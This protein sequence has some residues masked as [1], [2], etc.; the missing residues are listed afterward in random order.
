ME[1]RAARIAITAILQL[2]F[3]P[4]LDDHEIAIRLSRDIVHLPGFARLELDLRFLRCR[5]GRSLDVCRWMCRLGAGWMSGSGLWR[6]R[7]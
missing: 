5:A 2:W 7:P 3:D 4:R 6:P 1:I